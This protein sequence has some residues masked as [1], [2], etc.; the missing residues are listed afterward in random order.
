MS[1]VTF[2]SITLI[3]DFQYLPTVWQSYSF[4]VIPIMPLWFVRNSYC[5]CELAGNAVLETPWYIQNVWAEE[6]FRLYHVDCPSKHLSMDWLSLLQGTD[7]LSTFQF[8]KIFQVLTMNYVWIIV[9]VMQSTEL[10]KEKKKSHYLYGTLKSNAIEETSSNNWVEKVCLFKTC[11]FD[12]L[13][14]SISLSSSDTEFRESVKFNTLEVEWTLWIL[15]CMLWKY[16]GNFFFFPVWI[17]FVF[18]FRVMGTHEC[19]KTGQ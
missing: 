15:L 14:D 16:G 18:F 4:Q 11:L 10:P 5:Y 17:C 6:L 8:I 19:V 2:F 3:P 7:W 13:I 1:L 9:M 12:S